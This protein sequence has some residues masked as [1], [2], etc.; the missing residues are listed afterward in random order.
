MRVARVSHTLGNLASRL[1][2][3]HSGSAK[4]RGSEFV[5]FIV[6]ILWKV[7]VP[8]CKKYAEVNIL[9]G[10]ISYAKVNIDFLRHFLFYILRFRRS[11]LKF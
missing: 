4:E 3:I 7:V 8:R 10:R 11:N 9:S 6:L 1:A 2:T 5:I